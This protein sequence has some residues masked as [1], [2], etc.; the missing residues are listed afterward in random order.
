M[1]RFLVI[2]GLLALVNCSFSDNKN[3][4]SEIFSCPNIYFSAEHKTYVKSRD[5]NS[6]LSFSNISY[7]ASLN[8]FIFNEKCGE[9]NSFKIYPLDILILTE[10]FNPI[11]DDIEIPLFVHLYDEKNNIVDRQYFK[12]NG[13]LSYDKKNKDY[14]LGELTD[15]LIIVSESDELITSIVIGLIK[16]N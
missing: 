7:K 6:D 1:K 4:K 8:N 9:K 16:I 14:N 13:S 5:A 10:P 3:D 2:F 12:I 11:N 15:R